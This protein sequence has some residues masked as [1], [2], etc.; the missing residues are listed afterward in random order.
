MFDVIGKSH[1][2]FE[3][4]SIAITGQLVA[5]TKINGVMQQIGIHCNK[6]ISRI[7]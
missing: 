5:T 4:N 3:N 1:L 6:I 7:D 2:T